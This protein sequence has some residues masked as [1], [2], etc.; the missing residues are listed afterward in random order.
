[1]KAIMK[2][3]YEIILKIIVCSTGKDVNGTGI[4][5]HCWRPHKVVENIWKIIWK[6]FFK[7]FKH[8][9]PK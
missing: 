2:L 6:Y 7:S 8:S 3:Q 9:Y 4:S 5:V 1:M